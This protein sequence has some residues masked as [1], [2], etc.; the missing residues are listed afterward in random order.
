M[1][2]MDNQKYTALI[3]TA[4]ELFW[5]H[6]FKRVSVQEICTRSGVSKMTF[7]KFFSNKA[8]L[9]KQVFTNEIEEGIEKFNQLIDEDI[10]VQE[11]I[12]KMILMKAE[13]TNNISKEFMQD[14]YLGSE[15]ELKIF[16]ENKTRE[17]WNGLLG[18]WKKAQQAGIF[19]DDLKPEFLMQV[20]FSLIELMK[21]ERLTAIY[22][23]PQELILEFTRF[24]T[25]GITPER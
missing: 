15:P 16:V 14:F 12:E 22:H 10:S 1:K 19:R 8:E 4:R 5:K 11:K 25:Y 21:D 20:S 17:A 3:K 6:G 9:A 23:S 7:Y 2:Y 13:S 24:M 18:S